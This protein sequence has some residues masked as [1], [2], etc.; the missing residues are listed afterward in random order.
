METAKPMI[1]GKFATRGDCILGACLHLSVLPS[2]LLW[3][4]MGAAVLPFVLWVLFM[5]RSPLVDHHGRA[6]AN[7][8]LWISAASIAWFL[9]KAWVPFTPP[10]EAWAVLWGL[11]AVWV[12]RRARR[13][14]FA[15]DMRTP[16][17]TWLG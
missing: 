16:A 2:S 6:S 11:L 17:W 10:W 15:R 9:G 1:I 7:F 4:G 14:W 5:T 12:F 3:W 8:S 13:A